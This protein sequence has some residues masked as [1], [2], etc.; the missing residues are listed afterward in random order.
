MDV[1]M[2]SALVAGLTILWWGVW[3]AYCNDR[4][5]SQRSAMI[6]IINYYARRDTEL[7]LQ[8]SAS[9]NTVSYKAHRRALTLCRDV[10]RLYPRDIWDL[11]EWED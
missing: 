1:F 10:R 11:M 2:T 8:F 5:L 9:F 7:Y 3:S 4:T 6:R